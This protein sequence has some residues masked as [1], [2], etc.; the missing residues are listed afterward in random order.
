MIPS[1]LEFESSHKFQG[2]NGFD[3][4]SKR[5]SFLEKVQESLKRTGGR[6]VYDKPLDLIYVLNQALYDEL[7]HTRCIAMTILIDAIPLY[8]MEL[9]N[10][11]KLLFPGILDNLVNRNLPVKRCALQVLHL[12]FKRNADKSLIIDSL[13]RHGFTNS[14]KVL[15]NE[16]FLIVP[17]LVRSGFN[18]KDLKELFVSVLKILPQIDVAESKLPV[19]LCLEHIKDSIGEE[20]TS[21]LTS[22][23]K[24]LIDSYN[25]IM[26]K[27]SFSR[28]ENI[29]SRGKLIAV[30]ESPNF[31]E[32]FH[33]ENKLSCDL[34]FGFLPQTV[35]DKLNNRASLEDRSY[36]CNEFIKHLSSAEVI[37]VQSNAES[38]LEIISTLLVESDLSVALPALSL[39]HR[40]ITIIGHS[41]KEHL[42]I[43]TNLM[44]KIMN[45]PRA[46]LRKLNLC[47]GLTVMHNLSPDVFFQNII[48]HLFNK[49]ARVREEII[50]M[51]IGG[52]LTFPAS[53]FNLKQLPSQIT[54]CLLDKKKR[55]RHACLECLAV[56]AHSL[57]SGHLKPL[58]LA[59]DNL[60]SQYEGV[61]AAVQARLSRS[62]LP[63]I[64]EEGL[65]QYALVIPSNV[66]K[67]VCHL[68][69]VAWILSGTV[70]N[71]HNNYESQLHSNSSAIKSHLHKHNG[72]EDTNL[73]F[74]SQRSAVVRSAPVYQISNEVVDHKLSDLLTTRNLKQKQSE[75]NKS[76]ENDLDNDQAFLRS[77]SNSSYFE[78]YKTKMKQIKAAGLQADINVLQNVLPMNNRSNFHS[79]EM[80]KNTLKIEPYSRSFVTSPNFNISPVNCGVSLSPLG[81][82]STGR[83]NAHS[84]KQDH[85][86]QIPI[87]PTLVRSASSKRNTSASLKKEDLLQ[88]DDLAH[89][90]PKC[91]SQL[92]RISGIMDSP[93]PLRPTIHRTPS[94]R[95]SGKCVFEIEHQSDSSNLENMKMLSISSPAITD[96]AF[97]Q[98]I[99][100][101]KDIIFD[102]NMKSPFIKT[103]KARVMKSP[104]NS[105]KNETDFTDRKYF[106]NSTDQ[107]LK[108]QSAF[109]DNNNNTASFD[110]DSVDN[111]GFIKS[112]SV[113]K[114][115]SKNH[116][117]SKQDQKL[118]KKHKGKIEQQ[119][120]RMQ[121]EVRLWKE[122]EE[123]R[124]E[125]DKK[126]ILEDIK[127][128]YVVKKVPKTKERI[129]IK[130]VSDACI[131]NLD[132]QIDLRRSV[133][134]KDFSNNLNCLNTSLDS[135]DSSGFIAQ[136]KNTS[137]K[138][139]QVIEN[140]LVTRDLPSCSPV[141]CKVD[142]PDTL[143]NNVSSITIAL[144]LLK[145]SQ[146]EWENKCE[147]ITMVR[148]LLR[149]HQDAVIGQFHLVVEAVL[150]EVKNL[151]SQVTRA[152]LGCVAELFEYVPKMAESETEVILKG[153]LQK[154]ADTN[155]F[156]RQDVDTVMT[157]FVANINPVKA[158]SALIAFGTSHR[159]GQI[160]KIC[161]KAMADIAEKIG[162]SRLLSIHKDILV[163][164][165]KLATDSQQDSRYHGRRI[166]NYLLDCPDLDKLIVK[167]LP[168]A[169]IIAVQEVIENLRQK[170]LGEPPTGSATSRV[171]QSS[172][173]LSPTK[174]SKI[175]AQ[176]IS[177]EEDNS[178]L[179]QRKK[180]T[181][182]KELTDVGKAIDMDSLQKLES[183]NWNERYSGLD[184]FY[185]LVSM[186]PTAVSAQVVKIFDKFSPR[187][188]DSNSK[189][190]LYA[191]QI[192]NRCIP[193]LRNGIS[194]A[195]T[196]LIENLKTLLASKNDTIFSAAKDC[197]VSLT[198][199][200]DN[201]TLVLPLAT[202]VQYSNSRNR[203]ELTDLL[204]DIIPTVFARKPGTI[205]RVILPVLWKLLA[206]PYSNES[207][208]GHISM[209]EALVKFIH[210]LYD[211]IGIELKNEAA[212]KEPIILQRIEE[213]IG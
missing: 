168:K 34:L 26:L 177:H 95:M 123:Q 56:L 44:L 89:T 32:S 40:L 104:I 2:C 159:N 143:Q 127:K 187:L 24:N 19:L 52:L 198:K 60:E 55:V 173:G 98:E 22:L 33:V 141:E 118:H 128:S 92:R 102:R 192:L 63:S 83:S 161:A 148:Q 12:Y 162:Y 121:E 170:G 185:N 193:I 101:E 50:N 135:P 172:S 147:G 70:V 72:I 28:K 142:E 39:L 182:L 103:P 16:V 91:R 129:E 79:P 194:P 190:S 112:S 77:E 87:K 57:G 157:Y 184:D 107:S 204:N 139:L 47:I 208:P 122:S 13:L 80:L 62:L 65:I 51:I 74:V 99:T 116:D 158:V 20:F 6:L 54:F 178:R 11:L 66:D 88:V 94:G 5:V 124:K 167:D 132:E 213:L 4:E 160:R 186:N 61:L 45:D 176:H 120:L 164:S 115:R 183:A 119:E 9:D 23:E 49:S 67:M 149:T 29:I 140:Q 31:K 17:A 7:P 146:E 210:T 206:M 15:R 211:C 154:A 199:L 106:K 42:N 131:E 46:V 3:T 156:I 152:A 109:Q 189:V 200:V 110:T 125:E 68:P 117:L 53:S 36:A 90:L 82:L 25:N 75:K 96:N 138:S 130:D 212:T 201:N 71:N 100:S 203:A 137:R 155:Q 21:F 86:Q 113:K 58:V 111:Q 126:Y 1:V 30:N 64:N 197:M 136:T 202:A 196:I 27:T 14:N 10:H 180:K 174:S 133:E 81:F 76:F 35:M 163:V 166:L 169:N 108:M 134:K 84:D 114:A 37:L 179:T 38:I 165:A 145:S 59:V 150:N 153:I 97:T 151:R 93:F 195:A 144:Q 209:Q 78:M 207:S 73:Q 205:H 43:L 105:I 191:L 69:D 48:P 8:G 18:K 188:C 181:R 175:R 41:V 171:L 85:D